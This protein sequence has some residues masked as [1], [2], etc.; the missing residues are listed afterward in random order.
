MEIL[1]FCGFF[2]FFSF[3]RSF[4][5]N[6]SQILG[7]ISVSEPLNLTL[8]NNMSYYLDMPIEIKNENFFLQGDESMT[9]LSLQINSEF[10]LS[11]EK[12]QKIFFSKIFFSI[13]E[14]EPKIIPFVF[15]FK[16]DNSIIF[17]VFFF[18]VYFSYN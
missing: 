18:S 6:L 1:L 9:R 7:S 16:D 13:V 10:V 12:S 8:E 15:T 4:D 3:L 11:F 17:E 14:K 2:I 5:L